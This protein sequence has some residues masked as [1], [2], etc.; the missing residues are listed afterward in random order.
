MK[1]D[2][3][4]LT[5]PLHYLD[6]CRDPCRKSPWRQRTQGKGTESAETLSAIATPSTRRV[7]TEQRVSSSSPPLTQV[8]EWLSN[9]LKLVRL[10]CC[11]NMLSLSL[12]THVVRPF[13]L[14][15]DANLFMA[16]L[17]PP[18]LIVCSDKIQQILLF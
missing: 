3:N 12:S 7:R 17:F 1:K 2:Q 11:Q 16:S 4:S 14:I 10:F 8:I 13:L 15:E 18:N 5:S 6:P 9:S